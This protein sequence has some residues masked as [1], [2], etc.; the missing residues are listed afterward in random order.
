MF[1]RD[2]GYFSKNFIKVSIH[3]K[4]YLGSGK[5]SKAGMD[6]ANY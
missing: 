1:V 5:F 4:I 2:S 3:P 6:S